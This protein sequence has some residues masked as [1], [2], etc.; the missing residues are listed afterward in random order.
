MHIVTVL[1]SVILDQVT[2]YLVI[3]NMRLGERIPILPFFDLVHIK[4]RGAAFGI[5]H[6][7]SPMFRL[8]F[9]GIVTIVCVYLL[10]YWLGTT[11]REDKWQRF[12][13]AL[14]LGGAL[15]NLKDRVFFGQVTDFARIYY[16]AWSW[17]AF[18]IADS[19]I[20]IGVTIVVLKLL[21]L[22][23]MLKGRSTKT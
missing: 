2:K 14:I 21:P 15:G 22:G 6:D 16:E 18:N 10:V 11:P 19:A 17:P 8:I 5:F 20:S 13:L 12:A 9:F 1:V 7:S 3:F 23:S 4:N